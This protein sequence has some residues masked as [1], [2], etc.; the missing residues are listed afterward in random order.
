MSMGGGKYTPPPDN[1][2]QVQR[3]QQAYEDRRRAEEQARAEAETA[4]R[5]AEFNTN[6]DNAI[7]GFRSRSEQRLRDMGLDPAGYSSLIESAI[8]G[9]R[10][11]TPNL[12]PNPAQFFTDNLLDT[13]IGRMQG[14]RRANY[15]RQATSAFADNFEN[16]LFSDTADDPF[17]DAV[18]GRQRGEAVR[19]LDLARQRG[20]LD[21]T[22]YDAATARL[23]EMERAGRST[24]NTLGG[25]VIQGYRQQVRDIGDRA[26][27]GAS[28]YTLGGNFDLGGYTSELNNRVGDLRG[29]LEGDVNNALAGQNFFDLGDILTRGGSAQGPVNPRTSLTDILAE[30]ERVR[31]TDRGI[32]GSGTF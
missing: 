13:Q 1:S 22:G 6:R 2:V 9:G 8:A 17:I 11:A 25:S 18:L 20:S 27:E 23:N 12:D 29:R 7:S 30:R 19:A 3:E 10:S 5:T 16:G 21:Q 14:D 4:R 32:G 26:R 15:T 24:A 28:G 31:N